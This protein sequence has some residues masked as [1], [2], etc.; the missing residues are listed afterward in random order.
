MT[1]NVEH[2]AP[3]VAVHERFA[4]MPHLAGPGVFVTG[5]ATVPPT[6]M[7]HT[8]SPVQNLLSETWNE[9]KDGPKGSSVP[10]DR[11]IDGLCANENFSRPVRF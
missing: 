8:P 10:V 2:H 11:G 4:S 6:E 7:V 5:T 9:V 1:S 3:D